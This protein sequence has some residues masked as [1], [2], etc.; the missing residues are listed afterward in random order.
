LAFGIRRPNQEKYELVISDL[1]MP[2]MNGY[3]FVKKSKMFDQKPKLMTAF[4]INDAESGRF[5][6]K[7]EIESIIQNLFHWPI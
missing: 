1:R 5:L 7:V 4:Q 6:T 3:E 2:G